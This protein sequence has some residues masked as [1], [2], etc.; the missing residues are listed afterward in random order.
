MCIRDRNR[1]LPLFTNGSPGRC[2]CA[3]RMG[4]NGRCK[5]KAFLLQE[6]GQTRPDACRRSS[7]RPHSTTT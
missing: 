3:E 2:P 7:G 6:D 1:Q 4:L 5:A